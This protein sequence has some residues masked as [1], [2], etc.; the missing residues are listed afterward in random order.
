MTR[1]TRELIAQIAGETRAREAA[2]TRAIAAETRA[3]LAERELRDFRRVYD[4][5]RRDLS[6]IQAELKSL[7]GA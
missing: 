4:R 5:M 6:A 2:V 7:K 3:D 1:P